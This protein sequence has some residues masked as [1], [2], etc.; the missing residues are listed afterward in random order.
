MI[1]VEDGTV[2]YNR[3]PGIVT[4][5][6]IVILYH[7]MKYVWWAYSVLRE[8]V[9]RLFTRKVETNNGVHKT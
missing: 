8:M 3:L 1:W 5:Y 6:E 4:I 2:L 7:Q 9:L